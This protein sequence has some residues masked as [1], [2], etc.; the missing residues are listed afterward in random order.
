[1]EDLLDA[2]D[3]LAAEE[4]AFAQAQVEYTLS[5]SR[6]QRAIGTLLQR[7]PVHRHEVL[8]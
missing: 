3:R 5:L 8:P 4:F 6:F 2:Q 7:E 1:M